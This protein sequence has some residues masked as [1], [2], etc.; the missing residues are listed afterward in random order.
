M[1]DA[2]LV[3][4]PVASGRLRRLGLSKVASAP[5]IVGVLAAADIPGHNNTAGPGKHEPL[6]AQDKVEFAG[7]PLAIV[8][9]D[10]LDA[11]RAAA[12]H[13]AIDIAQGDHLDRSDLVKRKES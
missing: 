7:Q 6:L 12:E 10:T 11:A 9:A 1:P 3:L 2:A 5:G 4:S 13:A 8:V